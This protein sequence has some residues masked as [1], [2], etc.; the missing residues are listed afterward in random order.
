MF[1][2]VFKN[3][4]NYCSVVLKHTGEP[5]QITMQVE[6]HI[7]QYYKINST[8]NVFNMKILHFP[9]WLPFHPWPED[10]LSPWITSLNPSSPQTSRGLLGLRLKLVHVWF[11][12]TLIVKLVSG[13][14]QPLLGPV[15]IKD[16][17]FGGKERKRVRER[18]S[19]KIGCTIPASRA[20]LLWSARVSLC[21]HV[22]CESDTAVRP[23]SKHSIN[24]SRFVWAYLFRIWFLEDSVCSF[25]WLL[26]LLLHSFEKDYRYQT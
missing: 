17:D 13:L 16:V 24:T 11:C 5:L 2:A 4:W 12:P 18:D 20:L 14:V 10:E 21:L 3:A 15:T 9:V 6:S 7:N 26:H 25:L 19:E 1:P 22:W 23:A 8:Q